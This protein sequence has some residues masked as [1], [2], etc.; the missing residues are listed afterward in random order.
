MSFTALAGR[1]T[2]LV[3]L[4]SRVR[5]WQGDVVFLHEILAGAA[6]R[7]YGYRWRGSRDCR[8]RSLRGRNRF[9]ASLERSE[10]EKPAAK[11]IEELP[12]FAATAPATP[13]REKHDRLR[14]ALTA[15]NPDELSPR[16]ALEAL[17]RLKTLARD[18]S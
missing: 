11:L 10:R 12:L 3:N 15:V 6:D 2:R 9:L 18:P 13:A 14:E 8:P 17:Y 7:S 4:T 1:L 16:G 5:E